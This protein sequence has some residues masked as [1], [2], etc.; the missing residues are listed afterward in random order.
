MQRSRFI[1]TIGNSGGGAGGGGCGGVA[2]RTVAGLKTLY[3]V[4]SSQSSRLNE[5]VK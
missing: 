2:T 4:V 3:L 5:I 1:I